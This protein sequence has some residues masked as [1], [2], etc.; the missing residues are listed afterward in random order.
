M[1]IAAAGEP[2]DA[3]AVAVDRLAAVQ[4]HR[5]VVD[6]EAGEEAGELLRG[7]RFQRVA[8]EEGD[9]LAQLHREAEAGHQRRM[10]GAD[11]GA[12]GAVAL[13]EPQRLDGAVAGV[14]EAV[15]AAGRVSAS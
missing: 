14:D 12:P 15:R 10:V 4:H 13:F 11:V 5:G 7:L 6:G 8:A 3:A 2:A 1:A 9:V